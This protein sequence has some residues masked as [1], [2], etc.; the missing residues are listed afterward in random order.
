M[1]VNTEA[2]G[3]IMKLVKEL[4]EKIGVSEVVRRANQLIPYLEDKHAQG[5]A[6]AALNHAADGPIGSDTGRWDKGTFLVT[7]IDKYTADATPPEGGTSTTSTTSTTEQQSTEQ[8]T[9][10]STTTQQPTE[11]QQPTTTNKP[12]T[13]STTGESTNQSAESTN[14]PTTESVTNQVTDTP[15][16]TSTTSITE[17]TTTSP[18][19]PKGTKEEEVMTTTTGNQ[20]RNQPRN[21]NTKSATVSDMLIHI[22]IYGQDKIA[23]II[24]GVHDSATRNGKDELADE[25]VILLIQEYYSFKQMYPE[26]SGTREARRLYGSLIRFAT[27]LQ[28]KYPRRRSGGERVTGGVNWI[29]NVMEGVANAGANLST[30]LLD[31]SV[32][33]TGRVMSTIQVAAHDTRK[34]FQTTKWKAAINDAADGS[35]NTQ[36]RK[37]RETR[38]QSWT[39]RKE[40]RQYKKDYKSAVRHRQATKEM[41]D[42]STDQT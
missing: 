2:T 15:D 3:G 4:E 24:L 38:L 20:P 22:K 19:R 25:D 30:R 16:T 27:S 33:N 17:S 41:A 7:Q 18:R 29:A 14:Q 37:Y 36:L 26:Y 8:P 23:P 11:Q 28:E 34:E 35:Y 10:K 42:S 12:T 9:N 39:D 21:P 31:N 32:R 6:R 1:L 5:L 13:E 40:Y